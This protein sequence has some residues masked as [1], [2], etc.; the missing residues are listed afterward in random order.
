M[1]F[2]D[3]QNPG[4]GG[5]D[6]LTNAETVWVAHTAALTYA[7]G[8]VLVSDGSGDLQAL[9]VG[10]NT[11]VLTADSTQ[12]YGIKWAATGATGAN[13]ALS[14]L[15]SVAINTSLISDTADTDDLGSTTKEWLNLYIGD[16]GKIYLGLGQDTNLQRTAVGILTLTAANGVVV[17]NDFTA[18]TVAADQLKINYSST[19]KSHF[20]WNNT[21]SCVDLIFD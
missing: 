13:I 1:A 18:T 4:I 5:L 17:S 19:L 6:E 15:A 12:T 16:A 20:I 14:N 9:A 10:T 7:K 2:W 8:T 11:H 21:D 3:I